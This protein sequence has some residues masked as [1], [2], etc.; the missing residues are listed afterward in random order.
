MGIALVLGLVLAQIARLAWVRV[1]AALFIQLIRGLAMSW[2]V[3]ISF[4]LEIAETRAVSLN[5][6]NEVV[7][8]PVASRSEWPGAGRQAG[9]SAR[10]RGRGRQ[11][12][13][14]TP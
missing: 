9:L 3:N 6:E 1:P 10:A 14:I 7:P 12:L 2:P 13:P 8:N 11:P 4:A 5:S